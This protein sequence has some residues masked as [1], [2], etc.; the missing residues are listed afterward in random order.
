M[1]PT[2]GAKCL[3]DTNILVYGAIEESP[4]FKKAKK[5]LSLIR[6][7]EIKLVLSPQIFLEYSLVMTRYYKRSAK[8]IA[9][10]LDNFFGDPIINVVYPGSEVL[11]RFIGLLESISGVYPPDLF[12]AATA[13][14]YE[15]DYVITDDR[16]FEKIRGIK[17]YNPFI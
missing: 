12:L 5:L 3:L 6:K 4:K 7:Q 14:E 17:V 1:I 9:Q 13:M 10:D 11:K 8:N 15:V 16:D 2:S